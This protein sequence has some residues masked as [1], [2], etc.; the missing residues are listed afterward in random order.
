MKKKIKSKFIIIFLF[1]LIINIFPKKIYAKDKEFNILI[2]NSYSY[3]FKWTYDINSGIQDSLKSQDN[4]YNIYTE[5]MDSKK[6][7]GISYFESL[8]QLYKIK[9][10]NINFDLILCSDNDALNFLNEYKNSLFKGTPV[11]FSGINSSDFTLLNSK[12]D[13]AGVYENINI[14]ENIKCILKLQPQI[15]NIYFIGDSS[16]TGT[17]NKNLAKIESAKI[18]SS[19]NFKF[20][21]DL[22]KEDII[23]ISKEAPKDTAFL[24]LGTVEDNNGN[25]IDA[26][27]VSTYLYDYTKSSTIP[28]YAC[29]DFFMDQGGF[30]GGYLT[31][32]YEQGKA[33]GNIAMQV[34]NGKSINEIKSISISPKKY[35]FDERELLK[36]G[37]KENTLPQNSSISHKEISFFKTYKKTFVSAILVFSILILFILLLLYILKIKRNDKRQLKESY[38]EL[39]CVYEELSATEE[40]L[41]AQYEELQYNEEQLRESDEC[42]KL[43]TDGANDVIWQWDVINN[44]IFFSDK[45]KEITGYDPS[46]YKN[47]LK[48]WAKIVHPHDK[49]KV[50]YSLKE[51]I[52]GEVPYYRSQF[53]IKNTEGKYIW[54]LNRGKA[55]FN[56]EGK[57]I[58]MAGSLSDISDRVTM[59]RKINHLAYYDSLT[60]LPNRLKF[61]ER[62]DDILSNISNSKKKGALLFL[63]LDNFK[64]INDTLGHSFGDEVL[65]ALSTR[66]KNIFKK[67][68]V[69]RLGGDEF[70]ILMPGFS[71]K[72][73]I[74]KY[75]SELFISFREPIKLENLEV[76]I[77][78]S[79]GISIYPEDGITSSNLL[80]NADTAMY[81]AKESGKNKFEFFNDTMYQDVLRRTNIEHGLRNALKNHEFTMVYQPQVDTLTHKIRGLEA[82]IRWTSP[83]LG[84][85]SPAEFIPIAEQTGLILPL[86]K[87]ILKTVCSDANIWLKEGFDFGVVY[88]NI[89]PMQL[90][91]PNFM[92]DLKKIIEETQ[93][94]PA[95]LGMEIT[96]NVLIKSLDKTVKILEELK[97]LGIETALDDFGTGYSSLNYL[98]K[99]PIDY[100]KIDKSF[101][102][103]ICNN[104]TEIS[105]AKGIIDLSH[106]MNLKVIAEGVEIEG[107]F[108]LLKEMDCDKI[109]GYFFCKP[110]PLE[111]IKKLKS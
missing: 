32:G 28:Y 109:Q 102:D 83:I 35:I 18:S 108:A 91:M 31:S 47:Q 2:L 45:F 96:E 110:L 48:L 25:Y 67:D 70:L 21:T 33:A 92:D 51:H 24:F 101:I 111:E 53:R 84:A 61:I 36:Y 58:K 23:R 27:K 41:R 17:T 93:V 15:K 46:E 72:E 89:S 29:W 98:K 100:V 5:F 52:S 85:I 44:T 73:E 79:L 71:N 50:T 37:I 49:N 59:E 22:K 6:H 11:V 19:I 64:N 26:D 30:V 9:Y 103:T 88:I 107:Q 7:K 68:N 20:F 8:Y 63:D 4:H 39:S 55:L 82:L 57:A 12:K 14:Y 90:Q 80:K 76:F 81:K 94:N 40:E 97:K 99:L 43:A 54:V 65:K 104:E 74:K 60:E 87:W 38:E 34:L 10:S 42:Y 62:L 105:V 106:K 78:G 3:D 75:V 13:Y 69:C 77:T 1:L 16:T 86:S 56:D 95:C 66:L